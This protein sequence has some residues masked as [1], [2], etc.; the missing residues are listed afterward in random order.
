MRNVTGSEVLTESVA[1]RE[2]LTIVD[3][4]ADW[5]GPCKQLKPILESAAAKYPGIEV[6]GLDID[7]N[8]EFAAANKI[9]GVPTLLWYKGGELVQTTVGVMKP[10]VLAE[11]IEELM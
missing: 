4:Y 5:C 6:V 8:P 1:K 11:K 10:S 7:A 2:K 9:R 3:C